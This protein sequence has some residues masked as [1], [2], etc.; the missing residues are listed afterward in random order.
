MYSQRDN[1]NNPIAA[2]YTTTDLGSAAA[3]LAAGFALLKLDRETKPGR[4]FFVFEDSP[5]LQAALNNYWSGELMVDAKAYFESS[6]W[7]KS[8]I[9][10]G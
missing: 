9:Y 5:K 6:K 3:L 2:Q 4:A 1:V 7:L 8:R 10:N